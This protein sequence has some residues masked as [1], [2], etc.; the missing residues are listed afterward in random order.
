MSD[1]RC[2]TCRFRMS[3]LVLDESG[4]WHGRTP[5]ITEQQYEAKGESCGECHRYP[6]KVGDD[7]LSFSVGVMLDEWCGEWQAKRVALPVVEDQA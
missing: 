1:E 5:A 3:V 2:E 4:M 6:P 7:G